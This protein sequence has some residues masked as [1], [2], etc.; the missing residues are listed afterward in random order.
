MLALVSLTGNLYLASMVYPKLTMTTRNYLTLECKSVLIIT[1]ICKPSYPNDRTGSKLTIDDIEHHTPTGSVQAWH[2]TNSRFVRGTRSRDTQCIG[3]VHRSR[4][5]SRSRGTWV[6]TR[7]IKASG[8]Q[9]SR[10]K[11]WSL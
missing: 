1:S 3:V 11:R 9:R 10:G 6:K 4:W 7:G 8:E 5:R 2:N